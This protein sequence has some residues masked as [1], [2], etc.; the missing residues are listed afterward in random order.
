MLFSK[1]LSDEPLYSSIELNYSDIVYEGNKS[2]YMPRVNIYCDDESCKGIRIHE[3]DETDI[4][5]IYKTP[6]S[7]CYNRETLQY[8]CK[9]CEQSKKIYNILVLTF[10]GKDIVK[11]IK[12][13]EYPEIGPNIPAT[14]SKLLSGKN[15]ELIMK[16]LRSESQGLGIGA[17]SYYRRTLD[18][19]KNDLIDQMIKVSETINATEDFILSLKDAKKE[20]GFANS[21]DKIKKVIPDGLLINGENPLRLLNTALSKGIHAKDDKEC[22]EAAQGIKIILFNLLARITDLVKED[23]ELKKHITSLNEFSS[24]TQTTSE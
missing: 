11:I 17:F 22:L 15:R 13:G 12:V 24:K 4:N 23:K 3:I 20:E 10:P 18:I 7:I 6:K 8:R 14:A 5:S 21:V 9:H 19:I 2:L 16:G 1:F